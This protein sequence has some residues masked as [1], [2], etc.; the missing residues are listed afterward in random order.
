MEGFYFLSRKTNLKHFKNKQA[1]SIIKYDALYKPM[2]KQIAR[3][4]IPGNYA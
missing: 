3:K 4:S 2:K 1:F